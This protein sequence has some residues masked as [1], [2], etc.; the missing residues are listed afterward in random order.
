M[1]HE[2]AHVGTWAGALDYTQELPPDLLHMVAQ[3]VSLDFQ[4]PGWRGHGAGEFFFRLSLRQI[5]QLRMRRLVRH[6]P[7]STHTCPEQEH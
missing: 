4:H 7:I 3:L 5:P 6:T 1:H 2:Q